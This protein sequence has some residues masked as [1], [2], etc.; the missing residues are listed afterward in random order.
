M[1]LQFVIDAS[2]ALQWVVPE[3]TSPVADRLLGHRL[4]APDVLMGDLAQVLGAKVA[5][6]DLTAVEAATAAMALQGAEVELMPSRPLLA[7]AVR[8]AAQLSYPAQDC[9]YLALAQGMQ[10]VY[11]TANPALVRAVRGPHGGRL[12]GRVVLVHEVE[13][14]L[15]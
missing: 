7:D 11:V 6:G 9:L 4:L 15:R 3:A 14:F 12:A 1:S 2:V 10:L 5:L 8:L 13:R